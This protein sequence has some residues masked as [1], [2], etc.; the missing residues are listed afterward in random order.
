MPVVKKRTVA[1]KAPAKP[2]EVDPAEEMVNLVIEMIG[3]K[4][5]DAYLTKLD[6]AI[7]DRATAFEN[8]RTA[9]KKTAVAKPQTKS[10]SIAKPPTRKVSASG[11]KPSLKPEAGKPYK[12]NSRVKKVGGA[13]VEFVRFYKGDEAK[14]VVKMLVDK[15]EFPK[16]K[17][18][19]IPVNALEVFRRTTVSK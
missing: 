8:E 12:I 9:A 14:A 11:A 4:E 1:K 2:P 3:A 18:F 13:K 16:G 5:L 17:T 10:E 15:P 19:P 7:S 6:S